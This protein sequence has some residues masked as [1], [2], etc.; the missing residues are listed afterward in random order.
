MM[1]APSRRPDDQY[2]QPPPDPVAA[3]WQCRSKKLSAPDKRAFEFLW[4]LTEGGRRVVLLTPADWLQWWFQLR[5]DSEEPW[6]NEF[7]TR[8]TLAAGRSWSAGLGIDFLRHDLSQYLVFGRYALSEATE[9]L[10]AV[11]YDSREN[12]W[13]NIEAGVAHRLHQ[14]W[15]LAAGVYHREGTR[16]EA[17]FGVRLDVR[18]LPF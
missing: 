5:V 13:N 12:R 17:G 14:N 11:R 8:F 9:V 10:A 2:A 16:R 7:N 1:Q 6:V 3:V 4:R 15:Q 18:F